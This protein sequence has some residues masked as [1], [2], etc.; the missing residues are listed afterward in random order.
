MSFPDVG[1]ELVEPNAEQ[2]VNF[3]QKLLGLQRIADERTCNFELTRDNLAER[4]EEVNALAGSIESEL[5]LLMPYRWPASIGTRMGVAGL[6]GTVEEDGLGLEALDE[7]TYV[8][9]T[10]SGAKFAILPG[11]LE[12]ES[13]KI[14]PSI[15]IRLTDASRV[16][17][18]EDDVIV[19]VEPYE[20]EVQIPLGYHEH[21]GVF[22]IPA[23]PVHEERTV[24]IGA[25]V[26]NTYT[27]PL[28]EA[29]TE[30]TARRSEPEVA[31][32][33]IQALPEGLAASAEESRRIMKAMQATVLRFAREQDLDIRT[34]TE[35]GMNAFIDKVL[36]HVAFEAYG[37]K[38][39]AEGNVMIAVGEGGFGAITQ[40]KDSVIRWQPMAGEDML[41]GEIENITISLVPAKQCMA[42]AVDS[43]EF[44]VT[45]Y[46]LS[47]A[48]AIKN[49]RFYTDRQPDGEYA[50]EIDLSEAHS[51]VF[52]P[53]AYEMNT[54]ILA[55]EE[56]VSSDQAARTD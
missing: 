29:L 39:F 24:E 42:E 40:G 46:S 3:A 20:T 23:E 56:L 4:Q 16:R 54:Q 17:T 1:R 5:V 32:P 45:E 41:M 7:R 37:S 21:I 55:V 36:S 47:A 44:A 28:G 49:A 34:V 27:S 52:L 14:I 51:T 31:P 33:Y 6:I 43:P 11:L 18:N 38:F 13:S 10:I 19:S 25:Q 35:E 12:E 30:A 8:Q 53:A 26:V 2:Q 9:G 15:M 50:Q 22:L 48:V